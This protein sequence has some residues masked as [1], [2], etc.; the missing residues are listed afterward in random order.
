MK[1]NGK[2]INDPIKIANTVNDF[3]TNIGPK[4]A[5]KFQ[6]SNPNQF[7]KFMSEIYKQSMYMHKTTANEVKKLLNKLDSKKSPGFDEL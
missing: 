6:N 1:I 2:D 7:M 3:F 4:L 5:S